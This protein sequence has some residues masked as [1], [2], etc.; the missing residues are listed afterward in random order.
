M[1]CWSAKQSTVS[2]NTLQTN[3]D[4]NNDG[5]AE[6]GRKRKKMKPKVYKKPTVITSGM[7]KR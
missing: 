1:D 2:N 5:F 3:T 4:E 6:L 7:F